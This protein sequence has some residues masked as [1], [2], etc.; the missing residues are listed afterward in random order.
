[1]PFASKYVLIRAVIVP[2]MVC[3]AD[4][5]DAKVFRD[6]FPNH[7]EVADVFN[8]LAPPS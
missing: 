1:M 2:E 4:S 7:R 5:P 8:E 3:D 6:R